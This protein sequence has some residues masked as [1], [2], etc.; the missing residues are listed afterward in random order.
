MRWRFINQAE[1]ALVDE[2]NQIKLSI[3]K[4]V[5]NGVWHVM[6]D[7]YLQ[8]NGTEFLTLPAAMCC[9]ERLL[10]QDGKTKII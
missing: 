7:V 6:S 5:H 3:V 1:V 10:T 8:A 2:Y 9:T 4:R